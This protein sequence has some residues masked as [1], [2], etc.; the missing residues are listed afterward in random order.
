MSMGIK[1][2][3]VVVFLKLKLWSRVEGDG[4]GGGGGG[5]GGV[6]RLGNDREDGVGV[7]GFDCEH[8]LW[9]QCAV[10]VSLKG[11]VEGGRPRH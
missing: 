10:V 4:G 9:S 2:C 8:G 3:A 1:Q 11:K 6:N 7:I 5:G